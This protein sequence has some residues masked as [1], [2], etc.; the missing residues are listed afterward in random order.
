MMSPVA[1]ARQGY[2]AVM[3]G[4]PMIIHGAHH[5][6][7]AAALQHAPLPVGRRLAPIIMARS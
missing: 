1:V 5:K 3:S 4:R 2:D 6:V 7:M